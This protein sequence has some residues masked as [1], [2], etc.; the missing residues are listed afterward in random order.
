MSVGVAK[1]GLDFA[2][3][4]ADAHFRDSK[5][6]RR[7]EPICNRELGLVVTADGKQLSGQGRADLEAMAI[8]E[9]KRIDRIDHFRIMAY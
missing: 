5:L 1:N 3:Y 2:F 6:F 4:F 8:D 9:F 7:D